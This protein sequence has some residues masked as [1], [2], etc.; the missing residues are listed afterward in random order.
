MT[1]QS[2][3]CPYCDEH[4]EMFRDVIDGE[5]VLRK[6]DIG[7]GNCTCEFTYEELLDILAES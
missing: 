1:V 4:F 2:F 3:L 7:D 6:E 5:L